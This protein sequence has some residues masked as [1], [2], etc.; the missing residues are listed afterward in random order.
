MKRKAK[1][2]I[3]FYLDCRAKQMTC[4][5]MKCKAKQMTG[6]YLKRN[7]ELKRGNPLCD[8]IPIAKCQKV[9]K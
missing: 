3:G 6:F 2:M 5:F 7:T 9:Y 8:N 4:F 1:Q